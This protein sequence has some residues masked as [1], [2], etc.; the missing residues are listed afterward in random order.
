[1]FLLRIW[2]LSFSRDGGGGFVYRRVNSI[3]AYEFRSKLMKFYNCKTILVA[4]SSIYIYL[5]L[6]MIMTDLF[7]VMLLV[8]TDLCSMV[9]LIMTDLCSVV[10]LIMTNLCSVVLLIMTNL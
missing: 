4:L 8:M 2:A 5:L 7:S 6:Y 1:M 10:L 3:K 9:L